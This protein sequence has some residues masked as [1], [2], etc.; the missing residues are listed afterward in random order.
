MDVKRSGCWLLLTFP[1]VGA[2][3]AGDWKAMCGQREL[4]RGGREASPSR[5]QKHKPKQML[6]LT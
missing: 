4:T 5:R 6:I 1:G 3:A 2:E